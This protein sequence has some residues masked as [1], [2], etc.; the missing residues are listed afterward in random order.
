MRSHNHHDCFLCD[1]LCNMLSAAQN[2]QRTWILILLKSLSALISSTFFDYEAQRQKVSFRVEQ[3]IYDQL[4]AGLCKLLPFNQAPSIIIYWFAW[5]NTWWMVSFHTFLSN[6][7]N[8]ETPIVFL[9][10]LFNHF[11]CRLC[12]K[13]SFSLV[14]D[15]NKS[16]FN[17]SL[18][19][20]ELF[21]I[22]I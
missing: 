20:Q 9:F 16:C 22:N 18:H 1:E 19:D 10:K 14:K 15:S 12:M 21:K 17:L 11:P 3:K 4:T 13:I 8:Y 2:Q 7:K 5:S 6:I